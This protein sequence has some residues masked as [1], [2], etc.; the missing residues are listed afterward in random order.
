VCSIF[1]HVRS[2]IV[3]AFLRRRFPR[4]SCVLV[5]SNC[6]CVSLEPD[7]AQADNR[8][9]RARMTNRIGCEWMR[10]SADVR[11]T[12]GATCEEM[13]WCLE[14]GTRGVPETPRQHDCV[15]VAWIARRRAMPLASVQ[16]MIKDYFVDTNSSIHFRAFG[17]LK[18]MMCGSTYYSFELERMLSPEEHLKVLG[19]D[20]TAISFENMTS[21]D[22]RDLSGNANPLQ[23]VGVIMMAL[24]SALPLKDFWYS[25]DA[26][27]EN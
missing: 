21:R 14:P 27:E 3:H 5:F 7:I 23:T 17:D 6:L 1:V 11:A 15:N 8:I 18:G 4:T 2:N 9:K 10:H 25:N 24:L 12:L 20:T 26:P 22:I 16:E 13:P 19:Y